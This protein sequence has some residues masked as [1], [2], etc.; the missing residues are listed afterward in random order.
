MYLGILQSQGDLDL[1]MLAFQRVLK[2]FDVELPLNGALILLLIRSFSCSK[3]Q[4]KRL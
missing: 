1:A 3:A 2:E 4:K